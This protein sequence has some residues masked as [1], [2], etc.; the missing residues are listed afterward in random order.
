MKQCKITQQSLHRLRF[1]R[2]SQ[3]TRNV[4]TRSGIS[5]VHANYCAVAVSRVSPRGHLLVDGAAYLESSSTAD[6]A[7]RGIRTLVTIFL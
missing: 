7:E 2:C 6:A 1:L 3:D 4:T 5:N